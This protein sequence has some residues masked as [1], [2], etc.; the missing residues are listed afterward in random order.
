LEEENKDAVCEKCGSPM[1]VKTG[2]YGPFLACTGYPKCKNIKNLQGTSAT[3]STGI[4]CP[5]CK[6]G[7]IV[8]KKGRFGIFYSCNR[9]PECKTAYWGKPTGEKCPD[10]GS[11]LIE[12]KKVGI[13]CSNKTCEYTK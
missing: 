11:L 10:C 2:K 9:Y 6:Q 13:K 3:E 1:A 12:D 4:I 8:P 7:E 5:V